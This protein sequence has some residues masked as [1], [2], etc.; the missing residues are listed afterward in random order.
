MELEPIFNN[1]LLLVQIAVIIS[2]C[3]LSGSIFRRFGQP[4]V[5]GEMIGG[6]L[7][8]PTLLGVVAPAAYASLFPASSLVFL[9]ALS[10]VG[11][12]VFIYL[13]GVQVDLTELRR[14]SGLALVTSNVS[15]AVPL[16]MGAVLAVYLFPRYG[17]GEYLTFALFIGTAMS[18]TAFPVLARILR[19][20]NLIQTP[21]GSTAIACAAVDDITAWIL[22]AAVVGMTNP[23][24][25]GR[26]VWHT[27]CWLVAGIAVLAVAG[28]LLQA[29]ARRM[30]GKEM[31][32]NLL[33]GLLVMALLF[34]AAGEWTGI[35]ALA[36]AF[37]A[38]V[39][40][41]TQFREELV[42]T[43]EPVTLLLLVPVFFALTGIRTDLFRNF[44][45]RGPS[46]TPYSF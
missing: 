12:I 44:P 2:L 9:T 32:A 18:V 17:K 19:E 43:L 41:P 14:N 4:Q 42:R 23:N 16:L 10:H 31:P 3:R 25:A 15:V 30:N 29:L 24:A 40:T 6:I 35:H 22:L 45:M 21:L 20:R 38:G 8:G 33:L 37:L 13:V 39:V 11:L 27:L 36:G 34:G 5:V 46:G 28:R 7:L 26:P 1:G